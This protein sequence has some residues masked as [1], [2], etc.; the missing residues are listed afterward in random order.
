MVNSRF[1]NI[2]LDGTVPMD[3][4]CGW[5]D[6]SYEETASKVVKQEIRPPKE[7]IIPSNPK[8]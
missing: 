6:M 7:W 4:I 2:L 8:Y 5:I 1:S 3:E